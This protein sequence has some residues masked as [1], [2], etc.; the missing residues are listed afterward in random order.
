MEKYFSLEGGGK[1]NIVE[2][3]L[4]QRAKWPDLK[5]LIGTDS[6]DEKNKRTGQRLT[7]YATVIVYRYG[8]KGAHYIYLK[9]EVPRVK[10]MFSRLYGE[11]ERTMEVALYLKEEAPYVQIDALEFD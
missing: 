2:H 9:E 4:E 6:Q 8:T 7:V 1:V 3:T 11:A 5:L 10:T